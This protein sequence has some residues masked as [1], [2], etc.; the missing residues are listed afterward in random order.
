[1]LIKSKTSIPILILTV[2]TLLVFGIGIKLASAQTT[3]STHYIISETQFGTGSQLH[4]CSTNYCS[5][6]TIGD[7]NQGKASSTSY[8]AQFGAITSNEPLLE[9]IATSGVQ[10]LGQLSTSTTATATQ[11][12]KIRNYLS[13]GYTLQITGSPPSQG[14]HAL[15]NLTS[16]T[17]S[18]PGTEQFGINLVANTTPSIGANPVQLPNSSFSF[19]FPDSAYSNV[20]QFKYI[21]GD[22]V[23]KS[24]TSSGQTQFTASMIFNVSNTTPGGN[25]NGE[26]TA[27]VTPIY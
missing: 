26:Y 25:Y 15:N 6:I 20:N 4:N 21:D 2:T 27:V 5:R 18:Q 22:I 11:T 3:N 13:N 12:I 8:S 23:A 16:P 19:G 7:L 17:T 14:I 9:V 1:M 10:N 24:Y